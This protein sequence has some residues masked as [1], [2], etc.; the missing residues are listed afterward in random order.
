MSITVYSPYKR[1]VTGLRKSLRKSFHRN[2]FWIRD[3]DDDTSSHVDL[4]TLKMRKLREDII[5]MREM[6]KELMDAADKRLL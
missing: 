5:D 1:S 3:I 6:I 4:M 2:K